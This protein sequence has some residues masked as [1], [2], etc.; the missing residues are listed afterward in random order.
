MRCK[1]GGLMQ[2]R[3]LTMETEARICILCGRDDME[4]RQP[5]K[6][7]KKEAEDTGSTK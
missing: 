7:D 6:K 3:R 5:T 2:L 4:R 1:C